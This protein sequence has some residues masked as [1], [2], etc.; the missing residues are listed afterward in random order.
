MAKR[1]AVLLGVMAGYIWQRRR[2]PRGVMSVTLGPTVTNPGT[3]PLHR[4]ILDR[5]IALEDRV[6]ELE[7]RTEPNA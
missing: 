2:K 7:N 4:V 1:P 6:T 3:E 5:L